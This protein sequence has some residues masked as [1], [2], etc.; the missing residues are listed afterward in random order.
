MADDVQITVG[1]QLDGLASSMDSAKEMV[2]GLKEHVEGLNETFTRLAEVAGIALGVDAFKEWVQSSAEL[3]EKMERTA[4]MLGITAREASELSGMAKMTGTDFD[5]LVRAMERFD[6]GLA[7]SEKSSSRVAQA[8][9]AL[10]LKAS[11]LKGELPMQQLETLSEA[12]VRLADGPN[13]TAAAMAL[14]GRAGAEMIPFLDRG[15]EGMEEIRRVLEET[16]AVM[17]NETAAAFADTKEHISEMSLAWTGLSNKLFEVARGP[18]DAAIQA[19]TRFL[20]TITKKDIAGAMLTASDSVIEFGGE[21]VKWFGD[22]HREWDAFTGAISSSVSFVVDNLAQV[23]RGAERLAYPFA[24]LAD[25]ARRYV[26]GNWDNIGGTAWAKIPLL[27]PTGSQAS[28]ALFDDM[29]NHK[30][31]SALAGADRLLGAPGDKWGGEVNAGTAFGAAPKAQAGA[32][33]LGAGGRGADDA[34]KQQSEATLIGLNEVLKAAEDAAKEREKFLDD[35]LSHHKISVSEWLSQSI[36]ALNKELASVKSTYAQEIALAGDN[37]QKVAEAKAKEADLVR[38]INDQIVAD[39][40]KALD[41]QTKQWE[42]YGNQVSSALNSQLRSLLSGQESFGAAMK[43]ML[44]DLLLKWM[45]TSITATGKWI[46]DQ[47][48]QTAAT[49]VGA[50]ARAAAQTEGAGA[51]LAADA[52][53]VLK[54]IAGGAAAT[55]AGVFGFLAPV[56]GPAAAGP[57]AAAMGSVEAVGGMLYDTGAWNV[58]RDMYAGIH[59]GEMIVPQ[60]GGIADEFRAMMSGGGGGAGSRGA[61]VNQAL[62]IHAVD[63]QSV[64]D[65]FR[66]NRSAMMKEVFGAMRAGAHHG[67]KFS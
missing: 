32:M 45:E 42:D 19:I 13:K 5:G 51:G 8:L 34:A 38:K 15:K 36:D 57:A 56:M 58:P 53:N 24:L 46:A 41:D 29:I 52:A 23:Q 67:L 39:N 64:A 47:V 30:V 44:A 33:N 26:T 59:A 6:L 12:F 61:T 49:Q 66:W 3:G 25:D 14:L 9:G 16:G 2:G 17:S 28:K 62:H 60:R 65:M 18:I 22:V 54:E 50:T 63:S 20:E 10:G 7:S 37:A 40:R 11:S 31:A 4:A 27:D 21:A 43:K 35:E 1:A 55:F 48:A